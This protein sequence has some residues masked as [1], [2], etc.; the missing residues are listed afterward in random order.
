MGEMLFVP[1]QRDRKLEAYATCFSTGANTLQLG[2]QTYQF[3]G[4]SC[5]WGS[6]LPGQL[7]LGPTA[8]T[9]TGHATYPKPTKDRHDHDHSRPGRKRR[10]T[11][12]T[13]GQRPPYHTRSADFALCR[14]A[15]G[16]EGK[17]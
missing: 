7:T 8:F 2:V 13:D 10:A 5:L 17:M 1:R 12:G 11:G 6:E 3:D 9:I 15:F 4:R 14:T 16:I